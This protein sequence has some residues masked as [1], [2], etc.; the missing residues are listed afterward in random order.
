MLAACTVMEKAVSTAAL[1]PSF[2]V[3]PIL[4]LDKM[5]LTGLS[6]LPARSR[7]AD[8]SRLRPIAESEIATGAIT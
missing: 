1:M 2:T 5:L 4:A 8:A 6:F 3:M 7:G